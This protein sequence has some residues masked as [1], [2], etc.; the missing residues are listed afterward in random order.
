MCQISWNCCFRL[1]VGC[2]QP[3]NVAADHDPVGTSSKNCNMPCHSFP[4]WNAIIPTR[5]GCGRFHGEVYESPMFF[6]FWLAVWN[7]PHRKNHPKWLSCFS[8]GLKPPTRLVVCSPK[9]SS[10][11][12]TN[13]AY[14]VAA[15]KMAVMAASI[16][17]FQVS[18]KLALTGDDKGSSKP[19]ILISDWNQP[20][21]YEHI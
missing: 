16:S 9:K 12:H 20:H 2:C 11:F 7:F 15:E 19:L 21:V 13:S 4:P 10:V 1:C 5:I 6:H 8:E 3:A 14:M 18:A 17:P